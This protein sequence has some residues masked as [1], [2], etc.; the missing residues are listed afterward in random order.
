M[1]GDLRVRA[2]ENIS[3]SMDEDEYRTAIIS[4]NLAGLSDLSTKP[5]CPTFRD[6][7]KA[8]TTGFISRALQ[9]G[10]IVDKPAEFTD[11]GRFM[12]AIFLTHLVDHN[13]LNPLKVKAKS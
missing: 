1:K 2:V 3:F 13:R 7:R 4:A 6:N 12:A 8:P 5:P 9:H 11:E 10:W